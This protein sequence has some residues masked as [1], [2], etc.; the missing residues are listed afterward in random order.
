MLGFCFSSED[1][2]DWGN[3]TASGICSLGHEASGPSFRPRAALGDSKRQQR[4]VGLGMSWET[5]KA[6]HE[7]TPQ[8]LG[9]ESFRQ[10][11]HDGS[12][13]AGSWSR[14]RWMH[15]PGAHRGTDAEAAPC[16]LNQGKPGGAA[17]E[18]RG[19]VSCF[20]SV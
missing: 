14:G 10:P 16:K 15:T 17:Q 7:V 2:T 9:D 8:G 3:N 1:G 11:G 4:P 5:R 13:Q 19:P 20:N 6:D 18:T 12:I